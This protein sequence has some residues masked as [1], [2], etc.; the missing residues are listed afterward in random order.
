MHEKVIFHK[1]T[2]SLR[3]A[4]NRGKEKPSFAF[5]KRKE[6]SSTAAIRMVFSSVEL[7]LGAGA[8]NALLLVLFWQ[9]RKNF[10]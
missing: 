1:G 9:G 6:F 10:A 7:W 2:L 8:K 5:L 3:I 4:I